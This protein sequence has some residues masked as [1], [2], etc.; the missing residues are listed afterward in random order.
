M[1]QKTTGTAI[2][3]APTTFDTTRLSAT[4]I[5]WQSVVP[6]TITQ[7]NA[8]TAQQNIPINAATLPIPAQGKPSVPYVATSTIN[9]SGISAS[10][11]CAT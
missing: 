11:S 1:G 7:G 9:I 6:Q 2:F 10:R 5:N 4:P 8:T 3:V